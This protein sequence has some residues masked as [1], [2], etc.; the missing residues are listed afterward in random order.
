MRTFCLWMIAIFIGFSRFLSL[1]FDWKSAHTFTSKLQRKPS[2]YPVKHWYKRKDLWGC[3]STTEAGASFTPLINQR[4]HQRPVQPA[5]MKYQGYHK[6]CGCTSDH[7]TKVMCNGTHCVFYRFHAFH[8]IPQKGK[9]ARIPLLSLL[10]KSIHTMTITTI[11]I[12]ICIQKFCI[13]F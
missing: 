12:K 4:S 9:M 5:V 6:D 7:I 13:I 2:H 1:F 3:L 8:V 11:Q 10:S